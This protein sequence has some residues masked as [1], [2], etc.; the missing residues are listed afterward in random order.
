MLFIKASIVLREKK[1]S[2]VD[3]EQYIHF[4]KSNSVKE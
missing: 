2:M 3:P 4:K 1:Y